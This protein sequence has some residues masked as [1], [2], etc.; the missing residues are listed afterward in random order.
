MEMDSVS[1]FMTGFDKGRSTLETKDSIEVKK[2]FFE[3]SEAS[4][5][6]SS[7]SLFAVDCCKLSAVSASWYKVGGSILN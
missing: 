7:S 5:G 3:S 1:I 6:F 2:L 4:V